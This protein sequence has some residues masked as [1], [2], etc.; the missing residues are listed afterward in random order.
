[1]WPPAR[2]TEIRFLTDGE[3]EPRVLVNGKDATRLLHTESAGAVASA[4]A[5]Y[6]PVRAALVE[7]QLRFRRP[8][9]LVATV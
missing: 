4:I 6:P 3:G 5:A 7:L 8:P 2:R 9:G 1:M